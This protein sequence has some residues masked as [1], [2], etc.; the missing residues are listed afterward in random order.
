MATC[1]AIRLQVE[2]K[3]VRKSPSALT[4]AYRII[5]PIAAT[6]VAAVDKL[7]GG[8][9]PIGAISEMTGPESSG[10]TSLALSF[11][12]RLTHEGRVCAWIDTCDALHVESAAA[13]GIDLSRL[14][15]VRCGVAQVAPSTRDYQFSIPEKYFVPRPIK[16]GLHGGGFGPHPRNETKGLSTAVSGL[17]RQETI[18]PQPR[19]VPD[20]KDFKLLQ[21][22][23]VK[24]KHST[25]HRKPWSQIEQALRT[26]DLLLQGGG[27][28]AI[29]LDMAGVAPPFVSRVEQSIW[30][31]YRAAA[32][33]TQASLLL[34]TQHSCAKS[35]GELLLHFH[36]GKALTDEKTVFAGIEHS[37]EI[38]RRRFIQSPSNVVPM[39]KPPQP[40]STARW[41]SQ[42]IWVGGR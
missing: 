12:A 19:K 18:G 40:E 4:P 1:S 2:S 35:A 37:L 17:L 24:D 22:P 41:C 7:L 14:L 30:F 21:Q 39:K 33:R 10:H 27:F 26:T 16:Q 5:R 28:S 25:P 6:G 31:R 23:L 38:K 9:L 32:E 20:P 13:S 42:A 36:P 3:L 34:L 11:L 8:G 15:W 29:V